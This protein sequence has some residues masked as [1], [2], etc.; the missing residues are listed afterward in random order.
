[1]KAIITD[2][3]YVIV[4]LGQTGLSC[5]RY[6]VGQGKSV[7]VMDTRENP[8]GLKELTEEFPQVSVI[9]GHLDQELLC[10]ADEIILSP[11]LALSTPEINEAQKQGVLIRGDIDLF[12]EAVKVPVVAITGSNGKSTVTTLLGEMAKYAGLN[13]GVGGNIGIPAL[14]LLAGE[15]QLY[16]LELSSFQL[17][18]TRA[19]N[20]SSVVLL[21]L[22]E[23]HMDRYPSKMAYLQAKQRIFF[24]AKTVVVNDDEPLSSPLVNTQMR[25]LHYGLSGPDMNKYSVIDDAGER[26][27]SKGFDT[28][29]RVDELK[30]RGEHNI[31]NCLAALALGDSVG[32]SMS[33][34]L[35]AIKNFKGLAHRCEYVR[36][37]NHVDYVNDSK[38][39]N[40]GAVVTALK[41]LGKEL[42]GKIVLIAGGDAKGA[43]L[44]SLL[45]PV[46]RFVKAMILIGRD[47][48]KFEQLL[49]ASVPISHARTMAEAVQ[50]AA[51][52]AQSGDLVLL[53]P[54]CASFDMFKNYEHRGSVFVEEVSRL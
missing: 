37:V 54:A 25:V 43:D 7:M 2:K 28:L 48:V 12:S 36:T 10:Q 41:G 29:L 9:L 21:N 32:L 4:G 8:P 53:S 34:M 18:T 14:D 39:T 33:A 24:G 38:G 49:S 17:E 52:L 19:L 27:L 3:R 13:V 1:M 26:Y 50:S 23:D 35:K 42:S 22:S 16:V 31:S 15:R 47:A 40:P 51:K 20:A 6:L 45:E 44:T 5:V 46:T 30:I 11:G